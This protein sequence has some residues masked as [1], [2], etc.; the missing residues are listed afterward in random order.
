MFTLLSLYHWVE[1]VYGMC[2]LSYEFCTVTVVTVVVVIFA[3]T[4]LSGGVTNMPRGTCS[5]KKNMEGWK[6]LH[7]TKSHNVEWKLVVNGGVNQITYSEC[8]CS[9]RFLCCF[10]RTNT[11]FIAFKSFNKLPHNNMRGYTFPGLVIW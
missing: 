1:I 11:R 4:I 6:K 2:C 7:W 5:S 3:C 9:E 8:A 10:L